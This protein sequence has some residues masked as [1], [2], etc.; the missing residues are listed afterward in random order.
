MGEG[1][2]KWGVLRGCAVGGAYVRQNPTRSDWF[3]LTYTRFLARNRMRAQRKG[4]P[5]A[6]LRRLTVGND[7]DS[8]STF[9][10]AFSTG[11]G[12]PPGGRMEDLPHLTSREAEVLELLARGYHNHEIAEMLCITAETVNSHVDHILAKL[13][14]RT[15]AEAAAWWAAHGNDVRNPPFGG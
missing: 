14:V 6:T 15:R 10:G 8:R 1:A 9:G 7:R 3:C 11:A 4:E 5:I 13:G 2:G 12:G